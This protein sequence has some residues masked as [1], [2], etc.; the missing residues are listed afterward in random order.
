[1][2]D[3]TGIA[4]TQKTWNPWQGCH[5]VS[6]GCKNCYMFSE[7]IRYGQ[8]PN[9]VV[10]SKPPTFNAPL[11]WKEPALI[12]TCS[13]SD[14]F[15]EEADAWRDEAWQI[16]RETPHLTYQ[17]LTKRPERIDA[18][19]PGGWPFKNVML[20]VSAENQAALDLRLPILLATPAAG[21]FLS[22]EPLLGPVDLQPTFRAWAAEVAAY[23]VSHGRA[24]NPLPPRIDWT[25]VGG[26]SGA[27][28]RTMDL[29]WLREI[30]TQ[31]RAASVPVC[32]KQDSAPKSGTQGR[33]PESLW[34]REMP[35]ET[36]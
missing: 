19:L 23:A 2:G 25:I 3:T 18:C 6:P 12:F 7:K 8:Q 15:I 34:I 14:F 9:V 4:W 16:I 30:V 28:P 10:R 29:G 21:R 32:V 36:R 1:M 11:K 27:A 31:C 17:V 33:I 5:K 22:L 13:W 20:G 24:M 35:G 26:E